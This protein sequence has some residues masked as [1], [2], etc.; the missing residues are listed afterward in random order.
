[1]LYSSFWRIS[2]GLSYEWWRLL[3]GALGLGLVFIGIVHSAQV[4]HYLN[5]PLKISLMIFFFVPMVYLIF[6]TRLVRPWMA[7]KTPFIIKEVLPKKDDCYTIKLTSKNAGSFSFEPGQFVWITISDSPFTI[8]QHPFSFSSSAASDVLEFTA[9]RLGDFTNTWKYLQPGQTAY[10]EGPFGSFTLK[11]KPCFMVMGG[12]G[13]TPAISILK[14]I[15]DTKDGRKCILVYGNQNWESVPFREEL[16]FLKNKTNLQ[17]IHVLAEPQEAWA[18]EKG[19]ISEDIILKY[20]PDKCNEFDYYICGPAP[21]M[22]E[23]ELTFRNA[24]VDWK[25]IYAERFDFV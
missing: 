20:L 4:G 14:T 21:M 15:S 13:I 16:A 1:M 7:K 17:L 19:L 22:D 23:A 6:H 11:D 10:L 2:T 12:I 9:K 24:G 3:H 5:S 25:N 8:Q 18:G